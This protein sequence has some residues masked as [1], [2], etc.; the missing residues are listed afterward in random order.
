MAAAPLEEED[1]NWAVERATGLPEMW[2]LVGKH[3]P[4]LVG[5]HRLMGVCRA[6]RA[7]VREKLGTLPGLVVCGGSSSGGGRVRE[8]R[9]LDM[10]TLRWEP[11][12]ALATA[13]DGHACCAVRGSLV[14][15]GG[16]TSNNT[17]TS[18]VELLS[19]GQAAFVELPA[20]SCGAITG[21]VAIPVV[22]SDSALGQVLLLE[23]WMQGSGRVSTVRLVDLATGVCT[24][25]QEPFSYI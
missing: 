24:P 2:G 3:T 5:L 23:A 4:S 1:A 20:L 10:A 13:R 14:V 17:P 22:E 18:T 25:A 7:G 21:A 6:S 19:S 9:R 11:M 15:L 12:P 16:I 8:V